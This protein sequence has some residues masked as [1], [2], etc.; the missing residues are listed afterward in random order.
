MFLVVFVACNKTSHTKAAKDEVVA[1]GAV[2]DMKKV[3]L[4]IDGMTCEIGCARTI[5]SKLSKMEGVKMALVDFSEKNGIVE[6]NANMISEKEIIATV[7]RIADGEL[8]KVTNTTE[9]E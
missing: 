4:D 1:Q 9:V 2:A 6:Y 5:Q 3:S 8:Y 7:E